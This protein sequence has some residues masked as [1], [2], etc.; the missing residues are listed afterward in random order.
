MFGLDYSGAK[1]AGRTAWL[2]EVDVTGP[3]RLIALDP[4][5]RLAGSDARDAVNAW[6]VDR[7]TRS[8]DALWAMDF[9][10]GLPVEIAPDGWRPQLDQ[11]T[12]WPGDASTFGRECVRRCRGAVGT[13]H[14]RRDTDREARAPF[15]CFHYG[16][17]YQTFH[18]MRD[19]LAP[20][21]DRPRTAVYPFQ[22]RKLPAARR[23]LVES[24]PSSVL[25][26]WG[27]PHRNYKQPAG[28]PLT[29]KRLK[30]RQT[31]LRDLYA[32]VAF[33]THRRRVML[34]NPG[35]DALDAVLAAAGGWAA[36]NTLDHA[37]VRRHPRYPREG[38]IVS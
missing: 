38:L 25:K 10:F 8:T 5:G 6:L 32:R 24:C 19:V 12:A 22:P 3:P 4:L 31:I 21:A 17:I 16:I 26:R 27:L 7:I 29:A 11:V 14:V 15:D 20:L 34:R 28:G 37:A 35:G 36:W 1:H 9:P 2:A 30:N 13:M 18:G 33:S 23:V